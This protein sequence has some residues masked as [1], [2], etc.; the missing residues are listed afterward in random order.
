MN[1]LRVSTSLSGIRIPSRTLSQFNSARRS[2]SSCRLVRVGRE[3]STCVQIKLTGRGLD[4]VHGVKRALRLSIAHRGASLRRGVGHGVAQ[5]PPSH[6]GGKLGG[7][8]SLRL[9]N[10]ENAAMLN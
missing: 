8:S 1:E 7:K 10:S 4:A 9:R 5:R 2:H 6:V 3:I